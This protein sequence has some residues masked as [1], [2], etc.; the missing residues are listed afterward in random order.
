MKFTV[1]AATIALLSA[2]AA[3]ATPLALNDLDRLRDVSEPQIAPAGDWIAYTIRTVDAKADKRESHLW[4]TSFD[5]ARTVQLTARKGESES[6]PRFSPDG[7]YLA[8]LSGRGDDRK[9]DQVWL[10]DRLGGEAQAVTSFPGGVADFAWSPDGKRLAIIVAD[11]DK[12]DSGDDKK[13]KP[14]IVID[15]F[16]F[17]QDIN[18]YQGALRDHL[19]VFDIASRKADL[20]TPGP[21][22]E[23]LPSWSPDGKSIAF[24]SKRH[25]DFDRDDN[26]DIFVIAAQ[27]GATPRQI[28]T[29][30][31]ADNAA[32]EQLSGSP[33]AWSPDGKFI[34][35]RQGGDP[36]LIE[37]ATTHLAVVPA[38]GGAP[39][40]LTAALD[41]NIDA[42]HW[43]DDG[44]SIT[45]LVEDDRTQYLARIPAAGGVLQRV[46]GGRD[47]ISDY[48][49]ARGRFALL[50]S[51]P[52]QPPE[53]F[54]F[55]GKAAPRQISHA[56]DWLKQ[57]A[58][59]P[60]TE[61]AFKSKDGTEVHGFLLKPPGSSAGHLPTILRIHGGPQSQFALSFSFE[62][63]IL[64]AH[65]YAVIAANP[66]GSTGRGQAYGAAIYANWG[67]PD[68]Q[69]ELAAVDD[70]VKRGVADPN[71]LGVGGW[72]YGGMLTNYVIASDTRFKAA[73]SGASIADILGGYGNDQYAHDYETELGVPWKTT[74]VWEKISYPFLHADRIKTPTLFLGGDQDMNVPLHNGEQMYQALRSMNIDTQ[75]IVYPG[76]FH[77]LTVPS[78]RKDT[79]QRYIGW[80][81][82]HLKG[83]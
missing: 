6:A 14:P 26:W 64:A 42:P 12:S 11:E 34:A 32:D 66:R 37:Y 27:A 80:Y 13:T 17:M 60:V 56:N 39:R 29:Y 15:R 41:R 45:F 5:G 67:G 50:I 74:A 51:N 48:D 21:Y 55:D 68:V 49:A 9:N 52:T 4:M 62:W 35:Y 83:R 57:I 63:Q 43:S 53:V 79:L 3:S 19:Y 77:G 72:S 30:I 20:L 40:V 76:Q 71:R 78:Y 25:K 23:A 44:K 54:A 31:G 22:Y 65:G 46:A 10:L 70:A 38:A 1:L 28:T 61:T 73:T 8:F 18:G 2:T 16:A 59:A 81:D 58:L 7:R 24:V 33:P 75:L 82:R 36:K 47:E 69:D